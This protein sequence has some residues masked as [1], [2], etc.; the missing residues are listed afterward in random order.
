ML[1]TVTTIL[2]AG[3]LATPALAQTTSEAP[4]RTIERDPAAPADAPWRSAPDLGRG[5]QNAPWRSASP[6]ESA[7]VLTPARIAPPGAKAMVAYVERDE[8]LRFFKRGS[9][10]GPVMVQNTNAALAGAL[11][12]VLVV[13]AIQRSQ[14]E[15]F[16]DKHD[17]ENPAGRIAAELAAFLANDRDGDLAAPIKVGPDDKPPK[18]KDVTSARFLIDVS[19]SGALE[20]QNGVYRSWARVYDTSTGKTLFNQDCVAVRAMPRPRGGAQ[21]SEVSMARA[22]LS[23]GADYCLDQFK[24]GLATLDTGEGGR[25]PSVGRRAKRAQVTEAAATAAPTP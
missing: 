4:W 3:A 1:R 21:V 13:A 15:K 6:A 17:L 25:G 10:P 8:P 11:L 22:A 14:G 9:D 7:E 12:G 23:A 20:N 24:D 19:G 5:V 2:I 16:A 18:P